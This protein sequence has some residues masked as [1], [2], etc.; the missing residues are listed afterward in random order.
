MWLAGFI[1]RLIDGFRFGLKKIQSIT[2]DKDKGE[3]LTDWG[4]IQGV[5]LAATPLSI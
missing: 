1:L 3:A 4:G 5:L 2:R